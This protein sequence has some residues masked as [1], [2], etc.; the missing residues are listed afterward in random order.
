MDAGDFRAL[1]ERCRELSRV[2]VRDDVRQQLCQWENDFEAEAEA[3]E[4]RGERSRRLAA[5]G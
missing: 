4:K 1:A 2:A 3:T 5:G